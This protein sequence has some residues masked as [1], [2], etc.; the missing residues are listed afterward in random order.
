ME[1]NCN[2]IY[3]GERLLI[4][5]VRLTTKEEKKVYNTTWIHTRLYLF[6][7]LS[8]NAKNWSNTLK[9]FVGNSRQ[10]VWVCSTNL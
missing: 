7:P 3:E 1:N 9:H 2:I 4:H 10:I 6:N 8:A 5:L